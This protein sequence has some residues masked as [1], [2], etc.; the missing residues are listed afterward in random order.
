MLLLLGGVL[1]APLA[2]QQ[3][4]PDEPRIQFTF[5][6]VDVASFVKLIGERTGR[7]FVVDD[8]V[9]GTISVVSPSVAQDEVYPLF[10][11]ILESVGSTVLED[12]GVYRI[13][14]LPGTGTPLAP[15]IRAGDAL[16]EHGLVT[17]IFRLD[18]VP[19]VDVQRALAGV[20][21]ERGAASIGAS[22]ETNHLIVTDSTAII[23]RVEQ[24]IAD[25]D[26]PGLSRSM[27]LV[28]LQHAQA[29]SLSEQLNAAM[30]EQATRA[31]QLR[32]R[33]AGGT[34][35][36]GGPGQALAVAAPHSNSLIL[37]GIPSQL[38]ALRDLIAG[39][40][41][42]L[43]AGRGRLNAVF[44]RYIVAEE[45]AENIAALLEKS[46][47]T[48]PTGRR[49][50]IQAHKSSNAL[51]IDASP[52][53]FAVVK[54]LLEQIDLLPQQVQIDVVI[55]EVSESSGF[56]FGIE[57]SALNVPDGIGD[58][59]IQGGFRLRE[60]ASTG[61]LNTL[62]TGIFPRGL[63]VGV[64]RGTRINANGELVSGYPGI[65]NLN[66]MRSDGRLKVL[67]QT[68]LQ[69]QNN[70]EA[71]IR[72]VNEIPVLR[73]TIEGGTGSMRD[74]IQNI[75]RMD[76]GV[77]LSIT[78]HI[79]PEG[80]VR[81]VL[82]PSIE[83]VIDSGPDGSSFT[84]T[85]AK[86]EVTTT[87]SVEDGHTIVIAGLTREDE[88]RAERRVPFLGRIPI[89]GWLFRS[90]ESISERTDLLIFV[91]P[92]VVDNMA[93]ADRRRAVLES[94]TGLGLGGD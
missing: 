49:I 33:L 38:T 69:A 56:E 83:A 63:S 65:F 18:H 17:K 90:E 40:D 51:L 77:K 5:D 6:K 93:D 55:V 48:V 22:D 21:G 71:V 80:L 2:A 82:N 30:A 91:T 92:H 85:I 66:A 3:A 60:G 25:I 68:S 20:M 73:S 35:P 9:T 31:T 43:P 52:A 32:A 14:R 13:V 62:Q 34:V 39:M 23:R 72:S 94:R 11:S 15:V 24:I 44:L 81:M 70:Q 57:M 10:V 19:A 50:A 7:R 88:R 29:E 8:G 87:V 54:Q 46:A 16:P 84:P 67:S 28:H 79:I 58:T 64:A 37:V 89:L 61:L 12:D 45:A 27:E 41:V 74:V 1:C 53:D 36:S 4:A 86:R 75:D 26:R 59:V 76:V 47:A 78:P 42:D